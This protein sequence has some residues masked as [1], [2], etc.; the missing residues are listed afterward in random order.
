M[1]S[2]IKLGNE[3]QALQPSNLKAIFV[4]VSGW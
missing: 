2:A 4:G 3:R 1:F